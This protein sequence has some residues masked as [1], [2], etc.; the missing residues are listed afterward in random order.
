[1]FNQLIDTPIGWL[2]V[3]ANHTA[4]TA[5]HFD[6]DPDLDTHTNPITQ[7][8]VQ[9]LTE[10]FSGQRINFDVPVAPKGTAFQHRVWHALQTIPHGEFCSYGDIAVKLDNPKAVRA[11]GAANGKNPIPVIIP[12]HRVIG[13][14]GKLTGYAGGLDKK[15]TLLKLEG[16]EG[17]KA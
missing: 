14:S 1:M 9:E 6:A 4:V 11:V 13:A 12:C 7:Q 10:Y 2:N 8:A 5:I 17:I 15:T 3:I 16:I